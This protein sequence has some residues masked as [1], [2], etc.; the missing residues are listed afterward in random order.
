MAHTFVS[1]LVHLVFSTKHRENL[2]TPDI[3][4]EL[5]AYISGILKNLGSACLEINGTSNHLHALYSHCKTI[6]LSDLVMEVKKGSSKWIKTRAP[7]FHNF[8]WQEGYGAFTIG[9]SAVPEVRRYI[10]NQKE[11]HKRRSFEEEFLGL[12]KKYQVPFDPKYIW[13]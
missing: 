5:F 8:A 1:L 10:C 3:E 11:R 7:Y 13:D 4:P 12:L 6:A 9:Q 2:I